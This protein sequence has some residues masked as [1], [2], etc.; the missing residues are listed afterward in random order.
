MLKLLFA[1]VF[2]CIAVSVTA[3]AGSIT[4]TQTTLTGKWKAEF[5]G[6][7]GIRP[8]MFSDVV[9]DLTQDGQAITGTATMASWP[10][11]TPISDGVRTGDRVSI[12]SIGK[13]ISSSGYPKMTFEG[14]VQGEVIKLKMTWAYVGG[15]EAVGTW[16][17]EAKRIPK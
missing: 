7:E 16:E 14:T 12:T 11:V 3:L 10:G 9:L 4:Q 1:A 15:T 8:K 5:V 2:F 13:I 17:M 6:K